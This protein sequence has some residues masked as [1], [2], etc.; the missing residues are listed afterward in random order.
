MCD[1][2]KKRIGIEVGGNHKI[3]EIKKLMIEGAR[4]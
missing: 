3:K 1:Y 2:G 4:S